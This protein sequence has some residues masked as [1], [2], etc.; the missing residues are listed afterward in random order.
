M[1]RLAL[2]RT[3]AALS[4]S[5]VLASIGAAPAQAASP[6][7]AVTAVA[8]VQDAESEFQAGVDA[9]RR[10]D[11]EAAITAFKAVLATDPGNDD[12]FRLWQRAEDE[13]LLEML[14]ERGELGALTARFL[15]LA[16][17]GRQAA[18]ADPGHAAEVVGRYLE[19]D[20]MQQRQA[21]LELQSQYG[22][23][24]VPALVGPLG[25]RA[26][27][28]RRVAAIQALLRIGD[29]AVPPLMAVLSSDDELTRTNAA[30]VLGS[31][32]D[33][34]AAAALAWM[35]EG[36]SSA[37]ARDVAAAALAKLLPEIGSLGIEA[38]DAGGIARGMAERWLA[39]DTLLSHRYD[40]ALLAWSWTDGQLQGRPILAGL[41]D[42]T[43]AES[44]LAGGLGSAHADT[45]R[46]HLAAILAAQKA[47]ILAAQQ[48]PGLDGNE[49]LAAAVAG[50]P[51]LDLQLALAGPHRAAALDLLVNYR[52]PAAAEA[53]IAS[54]GSSAG[55]VAA[56]RRVVGSSDP[57]VSLAA[58]LNLAAMG[59]AD[60]AVVGRL[61]QALSQVPNRLC[62]AL[63]STGLIG[64]GPGWQ[65]LNARDPVA[66]LARA[67]T[68]PPKD[69]FVVQD[70]MPGVTLDTLVFG[71]ENDPRSAGVPI[72]IV[73]KDVEGVQA[74][75]GER[76]ASV[77][78]S[79]NWDVVAGVAAEPGPLLA[80]AM[81]QAAA[82]AELLAG[83]PAPRV[84]MVA[85][86][87]AANLASGADETTRAAVLELAAAAGL[88]PCLGAAEDI[89]LNGGGGEALSLA[90]LHAC[91]RLWAQDGAPVGDRKALA[92]ALQALVA[93]DSPALAMAAAEALGQLGSAEPAT[94]AN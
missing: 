68:F 29:V 71:L 67:K 44:A 45:L 89:V 46:A 36:D 73:T 2:E 35:A 30:S 83:M 61:G 72:V 75:Y 17:L 31:L 15:E 33:G 74:L 52:Q 87:A 26:V 11:N 24:A 21:L 3:A 38:Q 14:M 9:Y 6:R 92:D 60:P 78:D 65:L 34:R 57:R 62:M 90:A 84:K 27:P 32:R 39:G 55:E 93:G 43:L 69:V 82:A 28:D 64:D 51:A 59:D 13:V 19:G 85:D 53:L 63:G 66:G 1:L 7:P 8:P 56:L 10:G 12:A 16:R 54:M 94:A 80:R 47:E 18:Q 70:G 86:H 76:V 50:L 25:D 79:A 41:F 5:L 88:S 58:A 42:L 20:D 23:W 37:A 40:T 81:A 49:L 77:V 22:A 91:A 48:L 4:A